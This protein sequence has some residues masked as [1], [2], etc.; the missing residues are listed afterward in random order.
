MSA[1][2]MSV[3]MP[4]VFMTGTSTAPRPLVRIS[5][6]R[7]E[8]EVS[9]PAVAMVPAV[10]A[11]PV[12][13]APAPLVGAPDTL[14]SLVL[15]EG[16]DSVPSLPALPEPLASLARAASE[17][18][19]SELL[20]IIAASTLLPIG[21]LLGF[22]L[23]DS[24]T[25]LVSQMSGKSQ[26]IISAAGPLAAEDGEGSV[27]DEDTTFEQTQ[28]AWP[29]IL[30]LKRELETM[31]PEEQRRTKLEIGTNWPPRTD[32]SKPFDIN[33]EGFM[34]FQGP[35][36]LTA[37]QENMPSFFSRA[38]FEEV[39]VPQKLVVL[40]GVFGVSAVAVLVSLIIG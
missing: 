38:N 7:M 3:C 20:P 27:W 37:V 10:D 1:L 39:Q 31:S 29:A 30:A 34:F 6:P 11:L 15:P 17:S 14:P 36:P 2:L 16:L 12:D 26:E 8:L 33:R 40:G 5:H 13:T 19:D 28:S 18:V 25:G 32:S 23:I 35:T 4:T 21:L 24:L 22:I 9:D